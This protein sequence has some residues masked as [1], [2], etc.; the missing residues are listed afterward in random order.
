MK[1][2]QYEILA[3]CNYALQEL[4]EF[5]K[6]IDKLYK[7]ILKSEDYN[8]PED[9]LNE[10]LEETE[11]LFDREDEVDGFLFYLIR[12]RRRLNNSIL[13]GILS[14]Y[15]IKYKREKSLGFL[16]DEGEEDEIE[17]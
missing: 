6:D 12:G 11:E 7:I 3:S 4:K 5:K 9:I 8:L 13:K 17:C 1:E 14:D 15:I 2:V 10:I 16:D